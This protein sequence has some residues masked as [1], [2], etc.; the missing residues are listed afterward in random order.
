MVVQIE[1]GKFLECF[2]FQELY[3]HDKT[4]T[5]IGRPAIVSTYC[6]H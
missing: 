1:V 4:L 3:S 2:F 5:R 6:S